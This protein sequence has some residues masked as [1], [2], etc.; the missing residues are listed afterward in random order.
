MR[1]RV[2]VLDAGGING[3]DL[4]GAAVARADARDRRVELE[5]CPAAVTFSVARSHIIPGPNFG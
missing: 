2:D 5:H 3:A 4:V 1:A